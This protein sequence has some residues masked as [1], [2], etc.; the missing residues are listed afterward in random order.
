MSAHEN[1]FLKWLSISLATAIIPFMIMGVLNLIRMDTV[2]KVAQAAIESNEKALDA[3][4]DNDKFMLYLKISEQKTQIFSKAFYDHIT[5]DSEAFQQI[6]KEL[7]TLNT[8]IN[9]LHKILLR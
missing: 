8:R 6:R 9:H 5:Y 2:L 7:D 1:K 4:M 3:K